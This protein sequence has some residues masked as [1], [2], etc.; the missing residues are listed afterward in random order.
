MYYIKAKFTMIS[1]LDLIPE[2]LTEFTW[3]SVIF[4]AWHFY[5]YGTQL[6]QFIKKSA[7]EKSRLKE[8]QFK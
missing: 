2:N 7:M 8:N 3:N 5:F 6:E 1:V 4:M